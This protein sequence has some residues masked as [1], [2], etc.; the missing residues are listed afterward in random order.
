MVVFT[1]EGGILIG[2]GVLFVIHELRHQ[3]LSIS[4]IARQT[5]LA[6]KTVRKY[7]KQGLQGPRYGPRA[8]RPQLLDPYRAYLRERV[9]RIAARVCVRCGR[10]PPVQ[11]GRT[12]EVCRQKRRAADAIGTGTRPVRTPESGIAP[13]RRRAGSSIPAGSGRTHAR[14]GQSGDRTPSRKLCDAFHRQGGDREANG[15]S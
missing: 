9:E 8:P 15:G 1:I 3:G 4:A 10:E 12:C 11:G 7:L 5:G 6:R 14:C 2:N 13:V